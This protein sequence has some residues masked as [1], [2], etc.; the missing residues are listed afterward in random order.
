MYNKNFYHLIFT[1]LLLA[2]I[3]TSCTKIQKPQKKFNTSPI[4]IKQ[5]DTPPGADPGVPAEMGGAGFKGEGWQT[6]ENF[7]TIG[8]PKAFKGG[9]LIMALNEFPVTLRTVGQNSNSYFRVILER[10]IY[11]TLLDIDPVTLDYVPKLATHWKISDDKKEFKF[12]INPDARWADGKPVTSEDVIATWKLYTNPEILDPAMNEVFLTYE[13]PVA[14]SKYIL[15][16]KSKTLNFQQFWFFGLAFKILPAHYID[17]ISGKDFLSKYQFN[18]IPGSGPYTIS[19]KDIIK[20]QSLMIRRRSDYWAENNKLNKGLNNF[21]LVRFEIVQDPALEL[22][23][24][25]KGEIDILSVRSASTWNEKLDNEDLKRGLILKKRIF[26][27]CPT[28]LQGIVFNTRKAPFDDV[29]IRKAFIYLFNRDIFNQKFFFNSYSMIKSF[30]PNSIYENPSNPN[31]SFKPD[32]AIALLKEAGWSEKNSDGY[33]VKNGK[34][35][36]VELPFQKGMDRYLTIFQEDLKNVGIKLNLKEIDL[37][38]IIKLGNE[39]NFMILP[40]AW[41]N[42]LIPNPGTYM[43]SKLADEKNTSNWDGLK[44]PKIDELIDKYAITFDKNE[45]IK[46]IR[47]LDFIACNHFDYIFKWTPNY[48]RIAFQNKF[49]YPDCMMERIEDYKSI[50]SYWW[51]DPERAAEY[52]V[53]FADKTKSLPITEID[54]KFWIQIKEKEEQLLKK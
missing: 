30:F 24:F 12:R 34:I 37:P 6:N 16:V 41:E 2:F 17:N 18:M 42:Q 7:N 50:L 14:E 26:N 25:K 33:L 44:D 11:E 15:S 40:A 39:F 21:D 8:N 5:Y 1:V 22:E 9:S 13:Q 20:G 54:N 23:K 49:G 53:A 52:D 36:E 47:E 19:E 29:K 27:E 38:T 45:R 31:L 3:F 48:Q 4:S 32:S 35:F 28:N 46:I 43:Y 51:N 10:M